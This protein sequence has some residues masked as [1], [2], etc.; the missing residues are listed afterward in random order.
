MPGRFSFTFPIQRTTRE[1]FAVRISRF[2]LLGEEVVGPGHGTRLI[3]LG[4]AM[5]VVFARRGSGFSSRLKR[6]GEQPVG[7][8]RVH[9]VFNVGKEAIS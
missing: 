7:T 1:S 6:L 2:P 3:N 5:R 8:L 9:G 4:Q